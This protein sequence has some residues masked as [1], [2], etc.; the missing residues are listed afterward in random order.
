MKKALTVGINNYNIAPLR[1]CV[2]DSNNIA[3]LLTEKGYVVTQLLNEQATKENIILNLNKILGSLTDND[4]FIFHYSG[5]GSQIPSNDLTELDGLTEILCPFDLINQDASWNVQN[6]ITDNDL[7]AIFTR[8]PKISVECLLDC[9]HSGTA[10][11]DIKP[12]VGYRYIQSPVENVNNKTPFNVT[13]NG[14]NII[15]FS[16]AQDSETAADATIDNIPQGAFTA[17]LIKST[18]GSRQE[19]IDRIIQFMKQSGFTQNPLLSCSDKEK[20]EPLF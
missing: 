19:I 17:A 14:E 13:N 1:G 15:C 4:K 18:N 10:T 8:N 2:N 16:A 9:C 11:R 12:N 5:H 3:K 20:Q 6:I 7:H